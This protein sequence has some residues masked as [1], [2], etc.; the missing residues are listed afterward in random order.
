MS[1]LRRRL[2]EYLATR[3]TLGFKLQRAGHLLPDFVRHLE[4][5]GAKAVTVSLALAWAKQP[6]DAHR[7]WWAHRLALVRGFAKHLQAYDPRNEIPSSSLLPQAARRAVP[8]LYSPSEIG[9]LMD[10]ARRLPHP[11][12]AGTYSTLVG[13]LAVAGLRIGEAIRLDRDDVDLRRG[14]LLIR[15]SKFGKSREVP[16]HVTAVAALRSYINVRDGAV[17]RPRSPAFF[18]SSAGTRL[19]YSNAHL[20]FQKLVRA[21]AIQ[22]R[23]ANCRPRPHDLRH[24]F[25]VRTLIDW[26]RADVDVQARLPM[27]STYLGHFDT[28]STYWYLQA[29]PELLALAGKRLDGKWRVR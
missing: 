22:R 16:L 24:T 20:V 25:A 13:L 3:R 23:F 7:S 5:H 10:A 26:Y 11:L 15:N 18:I 6:Q 14:L 12:H 27:L 4:R 19:F 1:S 21:A 9:R 28:H 8:Y 2:A 17:P 29:A